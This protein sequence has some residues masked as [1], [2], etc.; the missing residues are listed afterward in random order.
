MTASSWCCLCK[1]IHTYNSC[2]KSRSTHTY[3]H[4]YIHAYIHTYIH[5]CI[6]THIHTYTHTQ[7]A[8]WLNDGELLVLFMQIVDTL[9]EAVQGPN[10]LCQ[11][12]VLSSNFLA[13]ANRCVGLYAYICTCMRVKCI[14]NFILA[15]SL[16][17][18]V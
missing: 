13:V 11:R 16:P 18:G 12:A 7:D 15:I 14:T 10:R 4:T 17:T 2:I 8:M 9:S 5:T 6:H 3:I 1:H